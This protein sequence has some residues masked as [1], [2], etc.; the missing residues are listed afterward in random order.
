MKCQGALG[1]IAS[2]AAPFAILAAAE[3][4]ATATAASVFTACVRMCGPTAALANNLLNPSADPVGNV[5]PVGFTDD[6]ARTAQNAGGLADD[7]VRL[8]NQNLSK[9]GVTVLGRYP[10]YIS[11]AKAL[12]ASYFDIGADWERL[13]G[14]GVDPWALNVQFRETIATRGDQVLVSVSKVNIP[15]VGPL[16]DEVNYLVN[17]LDY[18]WVNQWSLQPGG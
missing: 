5:T 9:T 11:K 14:E 2:V 17:Q 10:G 6:V 16:R 13:V 15:E 12:G 4:T 8:A 18:V 3:V 1:C 7:L